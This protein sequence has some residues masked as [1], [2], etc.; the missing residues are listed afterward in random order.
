V[1][2]LQLLGTTCVTLANNHALDFGREALLDTL[3]HLRAAGIA[4]VGAGPSEQDARAPVTF[5]AGALRVTVVGFADHPDEYAA[6][7]QEAGTAFADVSAEVPPWLREALARASDRSTPVLVFPHWGPNMTPGPLGYVRRAAQDL[8]D[9]GATLVAG[10][11]AHVFH[12][13]AGRVLYDLGDVLDDYAVDARLRNDL[14]LLWLVT[15][16]DAVPRRV[17]AVPLRLDF[18]R[19]ELATGEDAAQ[20]RR[21]FRAACRALGTEVEPGEQLVVRL[22][23]CAQ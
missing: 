1:E 9:A 12:G 18:C 10:H 23:D 6:G 2:V 3:E 20:V 21:R 7:A 19:T 8:L 11:S 13:V 22:G 4:V 16:E 17:E 15:F 14:G 5:D